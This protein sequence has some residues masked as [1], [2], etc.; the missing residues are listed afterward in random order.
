MFKLDHIMVETKSPLKTATA[1]SEAFGLPFAWP[2]IEKVEY[3]SVGVNFGKINF[4]LISF[5]TRFGISGKS[6]SG[7][8]G[9]AFEI[10]GSEDSA[11]QH[12]SDLGLKWRVGEKAEAHTTI[13]VEEDQMFPTIFLVKYHFD[14]GGWK[15]RLKNE[16]QECGGGSFGIEKYQSIQI[17]AEL[18]NCIVSEFGV[19]E[20]KKNQITFTTSKMH[21]DP[22]V[23][24]DLIDNLEI[25]LA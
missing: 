20:N 22:I 13:T 15:A 5:S 10:E 14:T 12:L 25:I 23:I 2:L 3:S 17:N 21:S 18:P 9:L 16:F 1:V 19:S 11:I 6:F 24:S 7:L 8:S 4:E